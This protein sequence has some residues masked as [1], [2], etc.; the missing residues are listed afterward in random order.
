[1]PVPGRL[2]RHAGPARPRGAVLATL[3]T[4][5]ERATVGR[6]RVDRLASVERRGHMPIPCDRYRDGYTWD[7]WVERLGDDGA[8]WRE[9]FDGASLGELRAEYQ[10]VPTPRY[11]ACLFDP[12]SPMAREVVPIV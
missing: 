12:A 4:R 10:S 2:R 3:G 8:S 1:G 7:D 9:Q 11:V 6:T 5:R